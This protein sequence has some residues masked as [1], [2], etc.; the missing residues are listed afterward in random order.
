MMVIRSL[1]IFFIFVRFVNAMPLEDLDNLDIVKKVEVLG[2]AT[3]ARITENTSSTEVIKTFSLSRGRVT[4]AGITCRGLCTSQMNYDVTIDGVSSQYLE[5]RDNVFRSA[6]N[7]SQKTKYDR[8]KKRYGGGLN[9][10]FLRAV[11]IN[12][13]GGYSRTSIDSASERLQNYESLADAART[14]MN[15]FDVVKVRVYG[16]MKVT[17]FTQARSEAVAYV[18]FAKVTLLDG[19]EL[20]VVSASGADVSVQNGLGNE[21]G[22]EDWQGGA[23]QIEDNNNPIF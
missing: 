10:S 14:I 7:D 16:S 21:L 9:I 23:E 13:G 5:S 2:H 18:K 1:V 20:R 12:L 15:S 17:S 4:R 3:R 11:G 19:S 6:L 8:A 22:T